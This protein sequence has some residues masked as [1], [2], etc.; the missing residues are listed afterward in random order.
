MPLI[1][2]GEETLVQR[3]IRSLD[4]TGFNYKAHITDDDKV[5]DYFENVFPAVKPL[6]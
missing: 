3:C 2:L 6:R 1:T 4:D 5:E